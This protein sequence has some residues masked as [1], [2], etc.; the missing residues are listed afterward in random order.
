M[1]G[2]EH[3]P[4]T[5]RPRTMAPLAIASVLRNLSVPSQRRGG[6]RPRNL[7]PSYRRHRWGCLVDC[8]L[9]GRSSN[10][11]DFKAVPAGRVSNSAKTKAEVEPRLTARTNGC[12]WCCNACCRTARRRSYNVPRLPGGGRAEAREGLVEHQDERAGNRHLLSR[13][14][15]KA[16][17]TFAPIWPEMRLSSN[18]PPAAQPVCPRPIHTNARLTPIGR[19]R[20]AAAMLS[21]QTPEAV[22]R[23]V[24]VCAPGRTSRRASRQLDASLADRSSR[25]IRCI[26]RWTW[27]VGRRLPAEAPHSELGQPLELRGRL[28]FWTPET[29]ERHVKCVREFILAF[30]QAHR[31]GCGFT[32][33]A[34]G[35]EWNVDR[36]SWVS[37]ANTDR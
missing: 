26:A 4:A 10:A 12:A 6:S 15:R 35:C 30:R 21:R 24:G 13:S 2:S 5:H 36:W 18:S 9:A 28:M 16:F 7:F 22:A 11:G 33:R 37:S 3:R 14:A 25:P 27:S 29:L 17:A 8:S 23:A 1:G 31:R 32:A 20:L 34:W 19:E